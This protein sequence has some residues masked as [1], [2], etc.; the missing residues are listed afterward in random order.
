MRP[1]PSCNVGCWR[2]TASRSASALYGRRCGDWTYASK[3]TQHASEQE[4]PDVQEAR[5]AWRAEQPIL[6]PT[7][8]I[9]LD[10]TW[11]STN[12]ARRS[13]RCAK[14]VRLKAAVPH[15]HWKTTT[16]LA[17][18]CHDGLIAPLVL[19]GP[20]DGESFLAYIE[21]FLAPALTPGQIVIMDNLASHKVD[22]VR[23]A[24]EARGASVRYLPAYSPDLNPI[25]QFF[26]KLKAFLRKAA[27]RTVEALWDAVAAA[28]VT[29]AEDEYQNYLAHA[30]Y[31]DSK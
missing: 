8:L 29:F 4:R 5:A 7:T 24:I 25:E 19:D 28:L 14:G 16:F 10:E 22:G 2:R 6:D 18:L 21:Q 15:G 1:W 27:T 11:I 30:G 17:G 26:A 13:G 23:E 9:F 31:R 20:I 12:M 3:K